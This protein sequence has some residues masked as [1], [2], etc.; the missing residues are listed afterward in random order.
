MRDLRVVD[1][2]VELVQALLRLG[3]DELVDPP[4]R[5]QALRIGHIAEH[6]ARCVRQVDVQK[7]PG[8]MIEYSR[9]FIEMMS[10]AL[11][12]REGNLLVAEVLRPPEDVL[13][14]RH[15]A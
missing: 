2:A 11:D 3:E 12:V 6:F 8:K 15:P 13:H 1:E 4:P 5:L 7:C 14:H 9:I 10:K